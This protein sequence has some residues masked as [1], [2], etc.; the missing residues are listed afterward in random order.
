MRPEYGSNRATSWSEIV[1]TQ[2]RQNL[3]TWRHCHFLFNFAVFLFS[4]LV[5]A[6]GYDIF[7]CKGLIRNPK[8]LNTLIRVL[9]SIWRERQI[10]NT[11]I[12]IN[13]SNIKL[14]NTAKYLGSRENQQ[15]V[16]LQIWTSY[17]VNDN[18]SEYFKSPIEKLYFKLSEGCW[19]ALY[20]SSNTK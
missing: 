16:R 14:L 19:I 9:T 20:I 5:A 4:N 2:W 13:F 18:F 1:K 17:E 7:I 11:K 3:L 12:G 8:I 15:G 10:R 6:V